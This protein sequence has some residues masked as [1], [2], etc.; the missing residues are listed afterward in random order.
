MTTTTGGRTNLRRSRFVDAADKH[1]QGKYTGEI[2]K[3][4]WHARKDGA[5]QSCLDAT[6]GFFDEQY[7]DRP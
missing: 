6:D 7:K 2:S 5:D 1:V 4:E 3:S